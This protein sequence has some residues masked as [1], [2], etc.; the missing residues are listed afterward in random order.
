MVANVVVA[1]TARHIASL[2]A[3]AR[4]RRRAE[5]IRF[6]GND[7]E[8]TSEQTPALRRVGGGA[9]AGSGKGGLAWSGLT[10]RLCQRGRVMAP[11]EAL[12]TSAAYLAN[13][14]EV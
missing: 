13:A 6:S 3:G 10:C 11:S 4:L 12:E 9:R 2:H 14:P 1:R 5:R 7:A 8:D